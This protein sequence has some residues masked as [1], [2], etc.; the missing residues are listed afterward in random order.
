M[1]N[2]STLKTPG[3][4]IDE[5]SLLP[6]S[7]VGVETGIPAFVGYT[8]NTTTPGGSNLLLVP[9]RITSYREFEAL[10]GGPQKEND[11]LKISIKDFV[12]KIE[13]DE[14]KERLI[15]REINAFVEAPTATTKI[16]SHILN[17]AVQHFYA[18]GGGPCYIVSVGKYTTGETPSDAELKKGV[19]AV[20]NEDEPTLIVVPEAVLIDDFSKCAGVYE[21]ALQQAALLQDR[22]VI[23]DVQ[24]K[25]AKPN[26]DT[27]KIDIGKDVAEFRKYFAENGKYGA[28]Y[29]PYLDTTIDFSYLENKVT[30]TH[31]RIPLT[32]TEQAGK[33]DTKTVDALKTTDNQMYNTLVDKLSGVP[34]QLP[35]S[36]AVAGIYAKTDAE[37]GVWKAPANVG[38]AAVTGPNIKIDDETQ[39]NLNVHADAGKSVNAIRSFTG[40]GTLVWGARTLDGNSNEW[41]YVNVRRFFNFVEESVKKATY[42]FVFEPNDANTW[43]SVRAMIENF[44]TLQWRAGA[45]QGAKP[46]QAFFVRVG[47]GQTM[48][49]DDVLNG[50]LIVEI[51][52]AVVRPAEFIVLRFMHKLPE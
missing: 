2:L 44:L 52:M 35:P 11:S 8:E 30:I 51:G 13:T 16:T 48:T 24:Q 49:A 39:K 22:F 27:L 18:N 4:Y 45:L 19:E 15:R 46:E 9:T 31:K 42:R 36:A 28:A 37:R 7:V 38:V 33:Y 14:S 29:Y 10:F 32:G 1:L 26:T 6:A 12:E 47:L 20:A 40:K 17:Y 25:N 21:L 43:I 34:M 23:M 50:R 3:V 41:R 5:V